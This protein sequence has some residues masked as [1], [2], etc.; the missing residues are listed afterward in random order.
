MLSRTKF[1]LREIITNKYAIYIYGI[2]FPGLKQK[3]KERDFIRRRFE[4]VDKT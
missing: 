4:R 2:L 3:I 1:I